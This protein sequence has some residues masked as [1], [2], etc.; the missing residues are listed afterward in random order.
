MLKA[1]FFDLEKSWNEQ[2]AALR[3]KR[4][5]AVSPAGDTSAPV[6]EHSDSATEASTG[7]ASASTAETVQPDAKPGR[8]P[9]DGIQPEW[10]RSGVQNWLLWLGAGLSIV[11]AILFLA[12]A[13]SRLGLGGRS[14][15]MVSITC[16]ATA[17]AA[18]TYSRGLRST[19]EAL[20]VVAISLGIIDAA[21]ARSLDFLSLGSTDADLYWAIVAVLLVGAAAYASAVSTLHSPRIL[22]LLGAQLPL[23]LTL[24]ALDTSGSVINIFLCLQVIALFWSISRF[25]RKSLRGI[26]EWSARL[27]WVFLAV[28]AAVTGLVDFNADASDATSN[29]FDDLVVAATAAIVFWFSIVRQRVSTRALGAAL[30]MVAVAGTAA[31]L[32][33]DNYKSVALTVS[34]VGLSIGSSRYGFDRLRLGSRPGLVAALVGLITA[35]VGLTY[36]APEVITA[37]FGPFSWL[38]EPWSIHAGSRAG[39]SVSAYESWGGNAAVICVTAAWSACCALVAASANAGSRIFRAI[40]VGGSILVGLMTAAALPWPVVASVV[41][42]TAS[43]CGIYVWSFR[44]S[45]R[46]LL[47]AA[48]VVAGYAIVW[49]LASSVTTVLALGMVASAAV[50][51]SIRNPL[52]S[53]A[54]T[55]TYVATGAFGA[56]ALLYAGLDRPSTG[57]AVGLIGGALT[58]APRSI[59]RLDRSTSLV[60]YLVGLAVAMSL[61]ADDMDWLSAVLLAGVAVTALITQRERVQAFGW[62]SSALGVCLAWTR[63]SVADIH[64]VEAYSLPVAAV[65]LTAGYLSF[66]R[67]SDLGSWPAYSAGLFVSFGPSLALLVID[68]SVLRLVLVAMGGL[69]A[70]S[71][72]ARNRLRAPLIIGGLALTIAALIQFGPFVNHVPRWIVVGVVGV[73]LIYM[74]ATYE[75]RRLD[76]EKIKGRYEALR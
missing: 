8:R 19:S 36:V 2:V 57:F 26:A 35:S 23:P 3:A 54:S 39:S 50:A 41:S 44:P 47:A 49:S 70:I 13:W 52:Q 65:L 73:S 11:A 45:R 30:T 14:L 63:L 61:T 9:S 42:L 72:G 20:A 40:S 15:V 32:Q 6:A 18:S 25:E 1:Q 46:P 10:S 31:A 66:Q 59:T 37:I 67:K 24:N 69:C 27:W 58:C 55:V 68:E 12:F 71:F 38:A 22:A 53:T 51:C 76:L 62:L 74:G 43:A 64:V 5:S 34:C 33:F 4:P 48:G 60:A 28:A 29:V 16:G 56:A 7:H 21:A 17:G 75:R